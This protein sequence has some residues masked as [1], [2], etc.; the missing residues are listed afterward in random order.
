MRDSTVILHCLILLFI[1]C[2]IPSAAQSYTAS[3]WMAQLNDG[4]QVCTLSLPG[5]HDAATGE[6]V[7]FLSA[8]GVT[9]ALDL[10]GQWDSGVRAFDL[11]PAVQDSVL[12]IYHGLLKTKVSFSQAI[13]TLLA[14]LA[15]HPTEFAI[16]LMREETDSEDAVERSLWPT[17]VGSAISGLGERAAI[18]APQMTVGDARGKILFLSRTAYAATD[19]GA[20]VK[21]WSHSEYGTTEGKI[22]SYSDG[23]EA[24]LQMQD[25]FA[26]TD[27]EKQACKQQ[28]VMKLLSLASN[29]PAG[30]WSINFLSGYSST[31]FGCTQ[32]AT[33][34]G[35]KLN[36]ERMHPPVVEYFLKSGSVRH[37]GI[38]FMDFAGVDKV[39]GGLS[40]LNGYKV[41]GKMLL[42]AIIESNF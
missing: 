37:S 31:L 14:K 34:A 32:I 21:G 39:R 35:Y 3:A 33:T 25:Y 20:E 11:R 2:R 29:A 41:Q 7:C 36:A 17:A 24:R 12:H 42:E 1:S 6:G 10:S 27:K 30:V 13:E 19:K 9:Q 8:F 23:S 28:A 18:F 26:P 5:A 38:V 22:V 16:V 4:R 40:R 15:E